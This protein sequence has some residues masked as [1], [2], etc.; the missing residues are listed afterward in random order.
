MA[1]GLTVTGTAGDDL[2]QAGSADDTM[3]GLAGNDLISGGAGNDS[4]TAGLGFDT[5]L[6]GAGDDRIDLSD[7]QFGDVDIARG[8]DGNDTITSSL[9]DESIDGGNGNDTLSA[10]GG[11]I[12]GGAGN[13]TITLSDGFTTG[14]AGADRF[15]LGPP[16]DPLLGQNWTV[17]IGD[18]TMG[19]GGDQIDLTNLIASLISVPD[20]ASLG[21]YIWLEQTETSTLI[22]L[23]RDAAGNQY[24]VQ[25][26]AIVQ[27]ILPGSLRQGGFAGSFLPGTERSYVSTTLM[28]G[29]GNDTL[30][31]GW[32]ADTI[33]GGGGDDYISDTSSNGP[34][35]LSGEDGND[36]IFGGSGMDTL[37]GGAG[38]DVLRPGGGNDLVNG[39]DGNDLVDLSY[40]TSYSYATVDGGA[41][42][43]TI[44]GG[45]NG[46][47]I[48]GGDGDDTLTAIQATLQ[49]GNGNDTLSLT[50]GQ[51]VGGAG[52][53][54][55]RPTPIPPG[56]VYTSGMVTITDFKT[57]AGG[58]QLDLSG[59]LSSLVG[60]RSGDPTGR[61]MW[62]E[63]NGDGTMVKIDEDAAGGTATGRTVAFLTGVKP[64]DLVAANFTG[65]ITPLLTRDESNRAQTG[66]AADD[67]LV[68]GWGNDTIT[69]A[70]GNDTIS[71][72]AGTNLLSGDVGND[73]IAGL[74]IRD[75][76][77]GGDGND[78]LTGG[79]QASVD[80][81]AG[82]DLLEAMVG[83]GRFNGG[84]GNDT[85]YGYFGAE[86]LDGG[87]GNDLVQWLRNSNY[88][89]TDTAV[90]T[91]HGGAGN[92]TVI[93]AGMNDLLYGDDGDDVLISSGGVM[94]LEGGAGN[95]RLEAVTGTLTGGTGADRFA[96]NGVTYAWYSY[97][98]GSVTI[99]DFNVAEGDAI[100]VGK[101]LSY[102]FKP[103]NIELPL[104]RYFQ[105]VQDGADTL[106]KIDIDPLNQGGF[107]VPD[108]GYLTLARLQNVTASSL[109][110]ANFIGGLDPAQVAQYMPQTINGSAGS[111]LL[112]SGLGND[113]I[114]GGAGIDA[115]YY[116]APAADFDARFLVYPRANIP[117]GSF[118][119]FDK[120]GSG[121][122]A[123]AVTGVELAVIG[124]R[125]VPLI[126]PWGHMGASRPYDQ[127]Q[128][129]EAEY[130]ALYPDVA[131]AVAKGQYA[132]GEAHYLAMGKAEGRVAPASFS[133]AL[134]LFD[135]RF[136]LAQNPDVSALIGPGKVPDAWTHF[137]L[138]GEKEGRDPNVLFDTDWYL[139]HNPDVAAAVATG[140]IDAL[141]HYAQYG[142]KEG[143]DP[144]R[145]FDTSLYLTENPDVA[146]AGINPLLHYLAFGYTE[147]RVL[148]YTGDLI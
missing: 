44:I 3:V 27:N 133:S 94:T 48:Q 46:D 68:G 65:G 67:T 136:Y 130:L 57:G 2:L 17:T 50:A 61:Y 32:G 73:T 71:D 141:T 81:G 92:D 52:I 142:W 10:I 112:I 148:H 11:T 31:G 9:G 144:S 72:T 125:V 101:V 19:S 143:R 47:Q 80:G 139:A 88:Y 103:N 122:G 70:A 59:L 18:F 12:A 49:G 5:V 29:D 76:I 100:D 24:G 117:G 110:A 66:T 78:V 134:V 4:I 33:K 82:N 90:D 63:Y 74:G 75:T 116:A 95:D 23:D 62:L 91:L 107:S 34:N 16:G 13:D 60:Y 147:G 77:D 22:R 1:T 28:G 111:D 132:S 39:G 86:Y 140:G 109:T 30:A 6:G 146:A 137:K 64:A 8:G 84:T 55:F 38:D 36:T 89:D 105:I 108:T 119:I 42:N 15:L 83:G 113:L 85:I 99:S 128:F 41:G 131:A 102:L 7:G 124:D 43:D 69:G 120:S 145:F 87:D 123:D 138:Y 121:F 97:S 98:V 14:G 126:S 25:T 129:G 26:V 96:P 127:S 45:T 21:R 93:G 79:S 20:A 114:Y 58:D 37:D 54:I 51:A 56:N 115:V 35:N 118:N 106:L 135:E 104:A 53:D 40:N